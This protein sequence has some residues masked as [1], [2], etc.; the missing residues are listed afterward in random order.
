MCIRDRPA[1]FETGKI[2]CEVKSGGKRDI[3]TRLADFLEDETGHIWEV[4]AD[5]ADVE[6][7]H[8][9]GERRKQERFAEAAE[10]PLVKATLEAI[11]GAKIVDVR[12][13]TTSG[14]SAE[15]LPL[16]KEA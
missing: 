4:H 7:L 16:T 15:I 14:V 6:T 9:A 8:E 1:S 5:R 3:L 13:D 2:T 11:P 12:R 10:D